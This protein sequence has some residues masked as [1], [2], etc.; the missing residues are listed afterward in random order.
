MKSYQTTLNEAVQYNDL[1]GLVSNVISIDQYK[2]K[3]GDDKNITGFIV[4]KDLE[5]GI[6]LGEEENKLGIKA[7][8][9]VSYTHLTLPT[10]RI[11]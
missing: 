5:N 8:S 11:V 9:T 2:S 3:I 7:S 4:P 10:K 6:T 1:R